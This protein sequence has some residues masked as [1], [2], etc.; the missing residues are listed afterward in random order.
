MFTPIHTICNYVTYSRKKPDYFQAE[1]PYSVLLRLI[2]YYYD[3]N[4]NY[5]DSGVLIIL[6]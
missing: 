4:L 1:E 2:I 6:L 5:L 3:F